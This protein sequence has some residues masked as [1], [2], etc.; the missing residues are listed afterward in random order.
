MSSK[1]GPKLGCRLLE[2]EEKDVKAMMECWTS[3]EKADE[4]DTQDLLEAIKYKNKTSTSRM[5]VKACPVNKDEAGGLQIVGY[6]RWHQIDDKTWGP[7]TL[8]R[9]NFYADGEL[10][11]DRIEKADR[12]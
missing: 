4:R 8:Q 10:T 2:A 7:L 6:A 11:T 3:N 12:T 1:G 5:I 9:K